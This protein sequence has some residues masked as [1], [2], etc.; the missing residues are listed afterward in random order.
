MQLIRPPSFEETTDC[1]YL[2][3]R[4]QRLESFLAGDLSAEEL[5]VYLAAGWRK[6]GLYYFRPSCQDCRL[7]IPLRVSVPGFTPSRSQRRVLRSNR[8]LR[9]TFGPP[10]LTDRVFEIYRLHSGSRFG[11]QIDLEEFLFHFFLPS[12]PGFQVEIHQ[13]EELLGVGFLDRS[14]DA[15]SSVYFCFDPAHAN[16]GLGT[17]SILEE[18]AFAE[19]LGLPHYYLGYYVPGCAKMAY[20]DRFHPREHF[21]WGFGCWRTAMGPGGKVEEVPCNGGNGG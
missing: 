19:R 18:I 4:K 16:R 6:F 7:C 17:F 9:V 15:L 14:D 20:K 8:D 21:D 2:P 11:R 1:P 13:G 10:R 5:S 3:G 12:C